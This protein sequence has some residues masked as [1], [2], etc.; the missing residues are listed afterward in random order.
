MRMGSPKYPTPAQIAALRK[1][2][3]TGPPEA[4]TLTA[5]RLTLTVPPSGLVVVE[6]R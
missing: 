6:I 1:A 5:G 4:R 3:E 2:A